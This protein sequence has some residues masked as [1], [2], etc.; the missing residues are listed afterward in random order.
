M[1]MVALR[2]LSSGFCSFSSL[3]NTGGLQINKKGRC[4][5]IVF[6][7]K[8]KTNILAFGFGVSLCFGNLVCI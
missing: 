2:G 1:M 5:T 7:A 4:I 8:Q 6:S 3:Q